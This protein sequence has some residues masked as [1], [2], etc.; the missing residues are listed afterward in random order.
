MSHVM[1]KP[2]YAICEQ[3][4]CRSACACVQSDQRLCFSLPGK[5]NISTCYS[6]NFKTLA[7]FCSWADWFECNLV[8]NPEDRFSRDVTQSVK[9]KLQEFV[10]INLHLPSGHIH[11]Y[12][13]D[14]SISKFSGVWWTFSFLFNLEQIFL[15]A[16]SEDS[17]Q[18][19][20]LGLHCFSYVPKKERQA[21]MG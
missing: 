10:F 21:N 5:Y 2:V 12:Q 11:P 7:S 9:L 3:Q 17:N 14:E 8:A 6:W 16:N 18:S 20:D 4:R 1:R 19:S 13:L 15:L